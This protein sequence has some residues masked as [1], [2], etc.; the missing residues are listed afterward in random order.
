MA[1][2]VQTHN[3]NSER[4][5]KGA[6]PSVQTCLT[7]PNIFSEQQDWD[8]SIVTS[9]RQSFRSLSN[10][11]Y[12]CLGLRP[13]QQCPLMCI[14]DGETGIRAETYGPLDERAKKH[15]LFSEKG[16]FLTFTK[17]KLLH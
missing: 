7:G 13:Q 2:Y 5:E 14:L 4:R 9:S 11:K 17:A 8:L 6:L 16:H 10:Q 3:I 1:C 12:A 15:H